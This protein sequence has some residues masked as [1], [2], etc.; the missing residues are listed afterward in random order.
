MKAQETKFDPAVNYNPE[1]S[2]KLE[3]SMLNIKLVSRSS[4]LLFWRRRFLIF[5]MYRRGGHLRQLRVNLVLGSGE[6]Q[7][8]QYVRFICTKGI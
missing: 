7:I 1:L 5:T 8:S 2:Y 6:L 4:F 3:S